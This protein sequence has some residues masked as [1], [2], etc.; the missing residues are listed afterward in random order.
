MAFAENN[1]D[2]PRRVPTQARSRRRYEAILDAAAA[3]F[4]ETGFEGA[5]TE[6]IAQRAGTSIGSLYQFFPNKRALFA[7]VAERLMERETELFR[8][9]AASKLGAPWEELLDAVVDGFVMLQETEPAWHAVWS[10]A[11]ALGGEVKATA[12]RCHGVILRGTEEVLAHYAPEISRARLQVVAA[13]M[14]ETLAAMLFASL[15]YDRKRARALVEEAKRM[16]RLYAADV[17]GR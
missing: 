16:I 9:V 1:D 4:A 14:V 12:E 11:L 6:A 7:G 2:R 13:V 5:T 15:R 17:L 8:E 3:V 10:S